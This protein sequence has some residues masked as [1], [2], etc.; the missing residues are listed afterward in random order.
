MLIG[1]TDCRLNQLRAQ[2]RHNRQ[3]IPDLQGCLGPIDYEEKPSKE[4]ELGLEPTSDEV[5]W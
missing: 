3:E 5:I 4:M 2:L 1:V